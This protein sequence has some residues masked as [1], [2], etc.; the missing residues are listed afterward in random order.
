VSGVGRR[1]RQLTT[2]DLGA[3]RRG[4]RRRADRHVAA[5]TAAAEHEEPLR[6]AVDRQHHLELH[7]RRDVT[8]DVTI[9]LRYAIA[10]RHHRGR[11]QP[12]RRLR[13]P[14]EIPVHQVGAL[15]HGRYRPR[16][17]RGGACR[18]SAAASGH[19]DTGRRTGRQH[20]HTNAGSHRRMSKPPTI[21]PHRCLLTWQMPSTAFAVAPPPTMHRYRWDDERRYRP[22]E[23][24]EVGDPS[25][26]HPRG[27]GESTCIWPACPERWCHRSCQISS[28]IE[29]GSGIRPAVIESVRHCTWLL[30]AGGER[31]DGRQRLLPGGQAAILVLGA[32]SVLLVG[33]LL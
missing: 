15:H 6:P 8:V 5:V 1:H 18:D 13:Q 23:R 3:S 12:R 21:S 10:R 14:G 24:R 9:R 31:C 28:P 4:L 27:T 17:T 7:L 29:P 25:G 2:L 26:T 16:R 11:V 30:P 19:G 22:T 33:H 20:K 32:G